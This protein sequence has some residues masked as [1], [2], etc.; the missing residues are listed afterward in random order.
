[1]NI[2]IHEAVIKA[3]IDC[4]KI[5]LPLNSDTIKIMWQDKIDL[6]EQQCKELIYHTINWKTILEEP[7]KNDTL[8]VAVHRVNLGMAKYLSP[9]CSD[10]VVLQFK[11]TQDDKEEYMTIVKEFTHHNNIQQFMQRILYRFDGDKEFK[12][13]IDMDVK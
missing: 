4:K 12:Y 6:D 8:N 9:L 3:T 2:N 7:G 10:G 11:E 5:K 1:M 13:S